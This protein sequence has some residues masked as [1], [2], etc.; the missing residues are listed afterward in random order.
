MNQ[1]FYSQCSCDCASSSIVSGGNEGLKVPLKQT[2]G[3]KKV[4]GSGSTS[5][6]FNPLDQTCI[7]PESYSI[8]LRFLSQIAGSLDQMGSAALRQSIESSVKSRGLE[9]LAKSLDTTPETLQL[10]VDGLTQPPDISTDNLDDFKR[11]IVSM[12]DLHDG[13]VLTGRVTNTAL[14]GAFVDIGVGR[15]GLIPKRFITLEKLPVDQRR[16]SLALGPGERVEVQVMNVDL[17]RNR[18]TLDLIRVLK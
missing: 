9:V 15:S 11:E 1:K 18:I 8:A 5:N 17:Q 12:N 10:I 7:H 3:K 13:M 16:R 4:K 2:A 6:Q 14:F